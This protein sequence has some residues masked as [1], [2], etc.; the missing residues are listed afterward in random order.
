[1]TVAPSTGCDDASS[2]S[3]VSAGGQ[4]EHPSLEKSSTMI[5]VRSP[6]VPAYADDT[7]AALQPEPSSTI[8]ANTLVQNTETCVRSAVKRGAKRK[9]GETAGWVRSPM[10]A[11][12]SAPVLPLESLRDASVMERTHS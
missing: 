9:S 2:R 3:T 11:P 8:A 5:G 1:M 6:V 10:D 12:R 4:L 7:S